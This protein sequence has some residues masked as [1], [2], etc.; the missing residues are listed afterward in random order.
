MGRKDLV[1]DIEA[2]SLAVELEHVRTQRLG[3]RPLLTLRRN[4]GWL[5]PLTGF[6][7]GCTAGS[8]SG[9]TTVSALLSA[10]FAAMRLQPLVARFLKML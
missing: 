4:R 8:A 10:G 7:A 9:R 6:V 2:A 1:L 5:V 3:M